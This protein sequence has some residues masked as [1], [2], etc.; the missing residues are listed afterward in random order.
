MRILFAVSVFDVGGAEV[1]AL[2]LAQKLNERGH[3]I[4]MFAA[5]EKVENKELIARYSPY[6]KSKHSLS[7]WPIVKFITSKLNSLFRRLGFGDILIKKVRAYFLRSVIKSQK[8][9]LICSHSPRSDI[10]CGDAVKNS[11]IPLV[12]IE[13]GIYSHYLFTGRNQLL[14]PLLSASNIIAVS[15]FC[16]KKIKSYV[17][18]SA[19]I[20]TIYNGVSIVPTHS[21]LQVRKKLGIQDGEIVFGLAARGEQKKGWQHAIDAFLKLKIESN[22]KV[23]LILIGGSKYVNELKEKY[24]S[25]N[26]IHFI[27]KVPNPEYYIEAV[28]VGLMLSMYQTEALSLI[29]IEFLMLGKPVIATNVG[30]VSEVIELNDNSSC[31]LIDLESDGTINTTKLKNVMLRFTEEENLAL[32]PA[33]VKSTHNKFSMVK[34]ALAYEKEFQQIIS[35]KGGNRPF[36]RHGNNLST[37]PRFDKTKEIELVN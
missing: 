37:A 14:K 9:D 13:H 5:N 12:M 36:E 29:A 20:S 23:H 31:K 26:D 25:H 11:N 15:D 30:G 2:K 16:N 17:G 27:G 10:T 32:N 35:N 18:A 7:D 34:C 3:E 19:Q 21:R 28:D 8:V 1:L 33:H 22:K 24:Q 6:I 4:I